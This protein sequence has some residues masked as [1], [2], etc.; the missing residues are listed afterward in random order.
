MSSP[1]IF[2]ST[3]R[4]PGNDIEEGVGQVT[5]TTEGIVSTTKGDVAEI[6]AW[7]WM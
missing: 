4:C 6:P 2:P 1:Y 5:V 3:S 7:Q